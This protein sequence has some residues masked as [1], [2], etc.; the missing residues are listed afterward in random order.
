M[1]TYDEWFWGVKGAWGRSVA[2][3]QFDRENE[4]R[5]DYVCALLLRLRW[6]DMDNVNYSGNNKRELVN[7]NEKQNNQECV[8]TLISCV[9]NAAYYKFSDVSCVDRPECILSNYGIT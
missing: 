4:Y 7:F 8:N 2:D 3:K 1:L 6:T 5:K 9:R